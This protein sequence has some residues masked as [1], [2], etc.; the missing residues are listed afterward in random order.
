MTEKQKI[1][2]SKW[3]IKNQTILRG[4][5]C[6]P[7]EKNDRG[8]NI[9]DRVGC[10]FCVVHDY[11]NEYSIYDGCPVEHKIKCAKLK[12]REYKLKNI[13]NEKSFK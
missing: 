6:P 1:I 8:T 4:T 12:L 5:D 13:N 2:Q 7:F 11:P 10:N 9:Q 3:L